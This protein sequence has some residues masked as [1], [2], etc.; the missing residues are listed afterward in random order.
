[1]AFTAVKGDCTVRA[2]NALTTCLM[3]VMMLMMML[4]MMIIRAYL[5]Q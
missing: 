5:L 2:D 3:M 4:L 1:M